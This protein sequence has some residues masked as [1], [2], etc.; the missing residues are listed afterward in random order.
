MSRGTTGASR[1]EVAGGAVEA[2][3]RRLEQ[4][5]AAGEAHDRHMNLLPTILN[6]F[7][8]QVRKATDDQHWH[9]RNLRGH[10][11]EVYATNLL[12]AIADESPE[13]DY[14]VALWEHD[15]NGDP[16]A[17]GFG[18]DK[19]GSPCLFHTGIPAMEL[20][21]LV[22]IG[23]KLHVIEMKQ[24]M[25]PQN[26]DVSDLLDRRQRV[27]TLA[28][29]EAGIL[30]ITSS[31]HKIDTYRK[32]SASNPLFT[33]AILHGFTTFWDWIC[34]EGIGKLAPCPAVLPTTKA[35]EPH[36]VL[37]GR[38]DFVSP[39]RR[40]SSLFF[41][42]S[43]G[44]D[45]FWAGAFVDFWTSGK[46]PVG[47]ITSD[48][49]ASRE[50]ASDGTRRL[51]TLLEGASLC[52][53]YLRVAT[54]NVV[55]PE[56]YVVAGREKIKHRYNPDKGTFVKEK[57]VNPHSYYF[58]E[59]GR[60]SKVAKHL[61]MD[62]DRWEAVAR[63]CAELSGPDRWVERLHSAISTINKFPPARAPA[64]KKGRKVRKASKT[65]DGG[66]ARDVKAGKPSRAGPRRTK[67][68]GTT[69]HPPA[70]CP[71]CGKTFPQGNKAME[72][73]RRTKHAP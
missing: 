15:G 56:L 3:A 55:Y 54:G 12:V 1:E 34:K 61:I 11:F 69:A 64:G 13:L 7:A 35:R 59:V 45:A 22:S 36:E 20:D 10:V 44:R 67:G 51:A 58:H 66:T 63:R 23:G 42:G 2:F 73:H 57:R 25:N 29:R 32:E 9:D 46:F 39:A 17:N 19:L 33:L 6:D 16:P 14:L 62:R 5:D 72:Q 40:V 71:V 70:T 21:G 28:G 18:R 4:R 53:V 68:R 49:V 47:I 38:V 24:D 26:D 48:A 8:K 30:I 37:P 31:E 52:V 60:F 27:E 43:I 50:P 65:G 41:D